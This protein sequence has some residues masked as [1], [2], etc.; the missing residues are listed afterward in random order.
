MID[1]EFSTRWI[2][3]ESLSEVQQVEIME[4]EDLMIEHELSYV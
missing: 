2:R 1:K 3:E 4:S